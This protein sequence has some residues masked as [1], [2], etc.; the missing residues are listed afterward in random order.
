MK[1]LICGLGSIGK[2]HAKN[3]ISLG[4]NDLLFFRE[5]NLPLQDKDLNKFRVFNDLTKALKQNP[6]ITLICNVTSKHVSTAIMCAKRGSHLFIEKP[7]SHQFTNWNK[8]KNIV[9]QKNLKIMVGYNMR[10]H[11]L[12]I[13]V[14]KIINNNELGKIY[15]IK[16][17]W[18]EYLP[19]W[20]PW[21]NYRK[22]YAARKDMGGGCSV[23]LSHELDT[24][25][26]LC[27]S[28]KK[29]FNIRT[30][31]FLNINV[32]TISDFLVHFKNNIVG[33][34]HIDFLQKPHSRN[35]EIVG[36]KNKLF[37]DYYKNILEITDRKGKVKQIKIKFE[38]NQ[39]YYD[40]IKYF[41]NC[42]KKNLKPKPN[43]NDSEY[44]L[45]NFLSIK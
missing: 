21:E 11:P 35:M 23:T 14:K 41:L 16:S 8:L 38:K 40:E 42:I 6:D 44:I 29:I 32:D 10:F 33:Y 26:W 36:I 39:M 5:R 30:N 19:D 22:S 34:I 37:F 2:R 12:M 17:Q 7:V 28:I 3:L 45:R 4:E 1:I 20:H 9:K 18:S 25:Y 15:N 27:G 31:K 13:K 43:L 24:L